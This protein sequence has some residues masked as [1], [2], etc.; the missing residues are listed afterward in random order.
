[1]TKCRRYRR[2]KEKVGGRKRKREDTDKIERVIERENY[3]LLNK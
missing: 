1:V 2:E 3:K